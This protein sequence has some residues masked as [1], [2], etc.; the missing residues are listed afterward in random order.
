MFVDDL[1]LY[2]ADEDHERAVT[3]L[4]EDLQ[5]IYNWSIV[6]HMVFSHEK[7]HVIDIGQGFRRMKDCNL[8]QILFGDGVPP[9]SREAKL[10][11]CMIDWRLSFKPHIDMITAKMKAVGFKLYKL[12]GTSSGI[13]P[14]ELHTIF[15]SYIF[16]RGEYASCIWIFRV[17]L[18][19]RRSFYKGQQHDS[20]IFS[21]LAKAYAWL[22]KVLEKTQRN[23]H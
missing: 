5:R 3:R 18:P 21:Y 11:G 23:L 9:V 17:F 14:F 13:S 2:L 19:Y 10:L 1:S 12:A 7:F 22:W 8:Q 20:E 16:P 6:N 4:N 15:K